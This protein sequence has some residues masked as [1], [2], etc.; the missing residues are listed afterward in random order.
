[1]QNFELTIERRDGSA[2]MVFAGDLDIQVVADAAEQLHALEA[3]G[4]PLIVL[5]LRG[6]T[7]M[8]SVGMGLIAAAHARAGREDRRLAVVAPPAPVDRAFTLTRFDRV[9]W[10]VEDPEDAFRE[11]AG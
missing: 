10:I 9:V 4:P 5:D 8:D 6:L 3:G 7:F 1:M 2:I 11:L